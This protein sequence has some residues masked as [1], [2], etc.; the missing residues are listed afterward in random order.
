MLS[1]ELNYY[2]TSSFMNNVGPIINAQ[3]QKSGKEFLNELFDPNEDDEQLQTHREIEKNVNESMSR[4]SDNSLDESGYRNQEGDK[5]QIKFP[6]ETSQFAEEN[7]DI[8]LNLSKY[9]LRKIVMLICDEAVK[10]F[11]NLV[12]KIVRYVKNVH[13]VGIFIRTK[14]CSPFATA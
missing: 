8:I 11:I 13:F 2:I 12:P 4:D 10:I 7:H 6:E 5:G 9:T 1:K 14:A 3:Q